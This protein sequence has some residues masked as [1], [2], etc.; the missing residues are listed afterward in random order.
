MNNTLLKE[1]SSLGLSRSMRQKINK[2]PDAQLNSLLQKYTKTEESEPIDNRQKLRNMIRERENARLGIVQKQRKDQGM[3]AQ[4]AAPV[5]SLED[6]QRLYNARIK[7]LQKKYGQIDD[8]T[9]YDA[10]NRTAGVD[11]TK[12]NQAQSDEH[13][14]YINIIDL[15]NHQQENKEK[16]LELDLDT[17]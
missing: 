16:E 8:A 6:K 10:L 9:Y 7:R 14:K 5:L 17:F 13:H 2:I 15:Y 11:V 1:L 3:E 12:L 4:P